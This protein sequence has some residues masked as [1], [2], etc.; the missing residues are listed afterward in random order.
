MPAN[1][2]VSF[3]TTASSVT[4]YTELDNAT[5]TT[6]STFTNTPSVSLNVPDEVIIVKITLPSGVNPVSGTLAPPTGADLVITKVWAEL[7][8]P[9]PGVSAT[10]A[11]PIPGEAIKLKAIVKNRGTAT[12]AGTTVMLAPDW[13][14]QIF[15][16]LPALAA[17][18]SQEIG[19]VASLTA[20][21]AG[22]HT[23]RIDCDKFNTAPETNDLNN[24]STLT[25]PVLNNRYT[26]PCD[27]TAEWTSFHQNWSSQTVG[28]RT[29]LT[30]TSADMSGGLKYTFN[31]IITSNWRLD[32]EYNWLTGG[33]TPDGCGA[34]GLSVLATVYNTAGLSG[35]GNGYRIKVHQGDSGLAVD[36]PK[37]IELFKITGGVESPLATGAT[38]EGYDE[39]GDS[40]S[41]KF[42]T[43]RLIYDRATQSLSAYADLNGDGVLE[44]VIAPVRDTNTTNPPTTS[45]AELVLQA[46]TGQGNVGAQPKFDNVVFSHGM[47][48][49][50]PA[51][52]FTDSFDQDLAQWTSVNGWVPIT[53]VGQNYVHNPLNDAAG[54]MTHLFVE[55]LTKG[56]SLGFDYDFRYAGNSTGN[57]YGNDGPTVNAAMLDSNN[58]GYRIFVQQGDLGN[59]AN[60]GKIIKIYKVTAGTNGTQPLAQGIGYNMHGWNP[61]NAPRFKRVVLTYNR[62]MQTLSAFIDLNND[63]VMEEVIAPVKDVPTSPIL[64]S[65]LVL[66]GGVGSQPGVLPAFDNIEVGLIQ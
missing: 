31:P 48:T 26:F 24:M 27:T 16:P 14:P 66:G 34:T 57:I 30:N 36:K 46:S 64:F 8:N 4:I 12:S 38:G 59:A 35:A 61:F 44:Q 55:P 28:T 65:K 53:T 3:G 19:P 49:L 50:V 33:N 18:A 2:T 45:F 17:G 63:G 40:S 9:I 51:P 62:K 21:T 32:F 20:P 6:G 29:F 13:G 42:K 41:T 60:N 37:Q 56:W 43:I 15:L 47:T 7:A 5:Y 52:F 22:F 1:V 58:N 23:V 10:P 54:T 11:N 25:V 39:C